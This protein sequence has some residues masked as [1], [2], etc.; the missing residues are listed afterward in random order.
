MMGNLIQG[1][2]RDS[3]G[4]KLQGFLVFL[5]FFVLL[6]SYSGLIMQM[7]VNTSYKCVNFSYD[8]TNMFNNYGILEENHH[9]LD[10][11]GGELKK[12]VLQLIQ[13]SVSFCCTAK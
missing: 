8:L 12:F 10:F 9:F 11:F 6:V 7:L 5:G 4:W 2:Y 1:K 3:R 13:C